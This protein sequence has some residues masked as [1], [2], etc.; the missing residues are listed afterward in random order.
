MVK[1]NTSIGLKRIPKTTS[2]TQAAATR[3]MRKQL[4]IA[5]G[6]LTAVIKHITKITPDA[7]VNA[8]QPIF[9]ES[10]RL[11]PKDK[12]RLMK[13]GFLSTGTFRGNPAVN[14]GYGAGGNP[15]YAIVVHEDMNAA[16][17]SPTQAK[18]L[19]QPYKE[20]L[21]DIPA[22]VARFFKNTG[23]L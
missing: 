13:S 14:L 17:R 16:H 20:Q 15:D 18:F 21:N 19:E 23:G 9:D 5:T 11:V 8:L 3:D 10:Q 1:I 22:R 2:S 6:N 4:A 12:L 7:L